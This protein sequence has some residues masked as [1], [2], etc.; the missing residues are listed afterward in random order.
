MLVGRDEQ[1]D[2]RNVGSANAMRG[3]ITAAKGEV[4]VVVSWRG[5][6]E[7]T[8]GALGGTAVLCGVSDARRRSVRIATRIV[9]SI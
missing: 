7:T 6:D 5:M 2:D 4:E 8:D 1:I 9:D 3:C